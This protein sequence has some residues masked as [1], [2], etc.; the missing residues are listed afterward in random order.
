MIRKLVSMAATLVLVLFSAT[1][2][3]AAATTEPPADYPR[4]HFV[5]GSSINLLSSSSNI[6]L[7]IQNDYAEDVVVHVHAIATNGRLV[8]PAAIAVKI[9][10]ATTI[11]AK[12]PVRATGVGKVDLVVW[13]E[14]FGGYRLNEQMFI[15][16]NVNADAETNII[17]AFTAI[18][19]ILGT[20]GLVRTL[21]KRRESQVVA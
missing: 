4:V 6:P 14:S 5:P 1:T 19:S 7:R 10:G 13:L 11:T 12:L 9:P 15:K 8:I 3:Q 16:V 21:R 2:A 20:L 17:V 18:V